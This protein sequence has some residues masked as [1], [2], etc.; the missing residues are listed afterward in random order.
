VIAVGPTQVGL[1]CSSK[2]NKNQQEES[3]LSAENFPRLA[4]PHNEEEEEETKHGSENNHNS[5]GNEV[6]SCSSSDLSEVMSMATTSY[7]IATTDYHFNLTVH[8]KTRQLQRA[9]SDQEIKHAMKHHGA[10]SRTRDG[11][12]VIPGENGVTVVTKGGLKYIVV[13]TWRV[14]EEQ[15]EDLSGWEDANIKTIEE[16]MLVPSSVIEVLSSF[17]PFRQQT[18]DGSR[19]VKKKY[20]L[21]V[22]NT[23]NIQVMAKPES[24][25]ILQRQWMTG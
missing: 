17:M 10:V 4:A 1:F 13:S 5:S 24:L 2:R 18:G 23:F 19:S 11:G 14:A 20:M 21:H 8:S 7:S 6:D 3:I 12:K 25:P 15:V 9:I 22:K 16:A